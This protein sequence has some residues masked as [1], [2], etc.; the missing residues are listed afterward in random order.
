MTQGVL[1][2]TSFSA[3]DELG[4]KAVRALFEDYNSDV[5]TPLTGE[6]HDDYDEDERTP[7]INTV[8]IFRKQQSLALS[9]ELYSNKLQQINPAS[10][11]F[12]YPDQQAALENELLFMF[13]CFS[14]QYQ[15]NEAEHRRQD[16]KELSDQIKKCAQLIYDLRGAS[17]ASSPEV[18]HIR[19]MVDSEKHCKYLGFTVGKAIAEKMLE[20]ASGKTVTTKKWMGEV[21]GRRLYWVWGGGL[22]ASVIA[23]LPDDFANRDQAQQALSVPSPLTGYMSWVLYYTRFA[24]NLSLLLKHTITGPWMSKEERKT[25]AWDRFKTQWQQRKFSLLND[26]IW[27]TANL[28][29]FFWLTGAGM[30]GYWGNALTAALLLMDVTLSIWKF[31]EESTQHNKDMLRYS[32]DIEKL[33]EKIAQVDSPIKE[34]LQRELKIL[35]KN[36]KL[37]E[38]NWAYKK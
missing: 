37:A 8:D 17:K 21:N 13:Y 24:I 15:L 2:S 18:L 12:L 34:T 7:L 19:K 33:E 4:Q 28:V 29:C 27:A 6:D 1:E 16:L 9:L 22:L 38:F 23:L 35:Q 36:Q 20:V 10:F 31:C 30:A 11:K 26:S 5:P 25:P 3:L 32:D 14:A